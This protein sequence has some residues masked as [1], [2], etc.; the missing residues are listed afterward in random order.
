MCAR[1]GV[2]DP[3]CPVTPGRAHDPERRVADAPLRRVL[4]AG[5]T[6]PTQGG[7]GSGGYARSSPM[8][9]DGAN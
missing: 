9:R 7:L 8:G 1:R 3:P 6:G 5:F 4:V 2:Q